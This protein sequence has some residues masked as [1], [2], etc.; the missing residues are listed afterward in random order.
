MSALKAGQ[1]LVVFSLTE[2]GRQLAQRIAQSCG[3]QVSCQHRPKPFAQAV[4]QAFRAGDA[5]V[6]ICATG[7]V[8]RTLAPL[9]VDKYS[10]PAVVV[11]DECGEFA[12]PLLSGHEGGA[13]HLAGELAQILDAQLVSTTAK[14]YRDP[15]YVAGMGCERGC[16]TQALRTLLMHSLA[17]AKLTLADLN[18]L[19]S[20]DIK[21]DEVGLIALARELELPFICY[22]PDELAPVHAQ[23][24]NPSQYVYETVGVYGVAESA[25]IVGA[26]ALGDGEAQLLLEKHKSA[27][28]TCAIGRSYLSERGGEQ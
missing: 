21:A 25:A 26:A 15:V 2:P 14:P 23:L 22:T 17:Q 28:A 19:T 20:I 24:A 7:I 9:L 11:L 10:D 18:A 27:V 6:F 4:A 5:L 13:N 1:R 12:I 3:A 16:S 8:V